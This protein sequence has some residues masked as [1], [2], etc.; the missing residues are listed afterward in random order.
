MNGCWGASGVKNPWDFP[1]DIFTGDWLNSVKSPF[2]GYDLPG[3]M[4]ADNASFLF[5]PIS[6]HS[7]NLVLQAAQ[8]WSLIQCTGIYPP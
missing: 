2:E 5:T 3:T 7:P 1:E 6:T 4:A 8:N